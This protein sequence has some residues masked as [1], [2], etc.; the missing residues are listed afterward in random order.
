MSMNN[1][2]K[3]MLRITDPSVNIFD[4]HE[5]IINEKNTLVIEGTCSLPPKQCPNCGC[6]TVGPNGQRCIVKN[7]FKKSDIRLEAFNHLP[8]I[9]RLSK[10]RYTC[11]ECV[12]HWTIQPYFVE[13]NCFIARHVKFKI[14]DL[15][16]EKI[17]LTLIAELCSVSIHT[18]IRIL[19]SFEKQLPTK[20]GFKLPRV[21]MVDEFRSHATNEDKMSFICADGETGELIDILSTRKLDKLVAH[22]KESPNPSQVKFLVSDMNASYF[23][24]IPKVFN[25]AT[26]IIDRFHIVQLVN[27][28]FNKFR[29]REVNRLKKLGYVVEAKKIKSN[30][31]TLL[32]SRKNIDSTTYKKWR[33]FPTSKHPLLT[34]EMMIDRLLSYSPE[35]RLAYDL[36]HDLTDA[37]DKKDGNEFFNILQLIAEKKNEK[38]FEEHDAEE[39]KEWKRLRMKY[40]K[41]DD[42]FKHDLNSLFSY[43]TGI[44][45]ALQH[46]YSNGKLESKNTHIK[47]LKRV[48]YGFKSFTNMRLRIFLMNGLIKTK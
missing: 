9:L 44:R 28:S 36:F 30:W 29:V 16:K 19:R 15:L 18:V 40:Q 4:V 1:S 43:E 25:D 14:M 13:K 41:L 33:S 22:F 20:Y 46:E 45:N 8:T 12:S 26:L 3:K 21:L 48:S 47:T 38:V 5:E 10:Q 6:T 42:E 2:I 37:F 17:S 27:K 24:L 35:L 23:E 7:G 32:K 31:R 34:E 39:E 11:R